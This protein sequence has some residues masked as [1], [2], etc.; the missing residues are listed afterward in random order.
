[1][2]LPSFRGI[3]GPGV[4]KRVSREGAG[5]ARAWGGMLRAWSLSFSF[6]CLPLPARVLWRGLFACGQGV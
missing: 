3:L 2:R 1:M 4:F 6:W 5:W